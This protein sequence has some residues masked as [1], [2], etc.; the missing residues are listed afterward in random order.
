MLVFGNGLVPARVVGADADRMG[1]EHYGVE[2]QETMAAR[3]ERIVVE[4]MKRRREQEFATLKR[5]IISTTN[6][7]YQLR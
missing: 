7:T 1:A 3:A 5:S 6:R 4:E 2:R